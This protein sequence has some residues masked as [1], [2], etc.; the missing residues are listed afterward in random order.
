MKLHISSLTRKY[1]VLMTTLCVSVGA[2]VAFPS[3]RLHELERRS[4][5]LTQHQAEGVALLSRS[6]QT[7]Q[8]LTAEIAARMPDGRANRKALERIDAAKSVITGDLTEAGKADATHAAA[9]S[10]IAGSVRA[11]FAACE[12]RIHLGSG[13]SD[14]RARGENQVMAAPDCSPLFAGLATKTKDQADALLAAQG[15]INAQ[16]E[17]KARATVRTAW[18]ATLCGLLLVMALGA[19]LVRTTI[20]KPVDRLGKIMVRLAGGDLGVEAPGVGRKD[21]LGAMA[22]AVMALKLAGIEKQRREAEA[23]AARIAIEDE[24]GRNEA[25]RA[26]TAREQAMALEALSRGLGQLAGGDLAHALDQPFARD[27]EGLRADYNAAAAGLRDTIAEVA[28]KTAA[29]R[30][31]GE[32]SFS[33][34]NDLL[35]R[36][37]QQAVGLEE[38][39]TA[40][41][42]IIANAHKTA[43]G[44]L[45]AR[46]AAA[47]TKADAE[48]SGAAVCA[49]A[50]ALGGIG[51]SSRQIGQ[52]IRAI[53]EIAVQLEVLALNRDEGA[54]RPGDAGRGFAVSDSDVGDLARRTAAAAQEI[55]TLLL[56]CDTQANTGLDWMDEAGAALDRITPQVARVSAVAIE[57]AASAWEQAIGLSQ[58]NAAISQMDQVYRQNTASIKQSAAAAAGLREET[59][60]L[61]TLV[62]GFRIADAP[63]QSRPV[64]PTR[65]TLRLVGGAG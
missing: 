23:T 56:S 37:E 12:D 41:E 5:T 57:L 46:N 21:E 42:Q 20:A 38:S 2:A 13:A 14:L 55:K 45:E 35:R 64:V 47:I 39:A 4:S 62:A 18:I 9:Y 19:A 24:L 3:N 31:C 27:Y 40:L 32:G 25:R 65:P 29:I 48:R 34:V 61:M 58:L 6:S 30:L 15:V 43:A 10:R 59:E 63:P 16:L 8:M 49:A 54:A 44:A 22:R 50:A 33:A 51:Q 26:Q 11:V 52:I 28:A 36:S 17:N 7:A 53:E 1:L 60:R